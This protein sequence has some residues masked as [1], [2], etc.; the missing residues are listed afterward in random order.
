LKKLL[1]SLLPD[2]A[3]G[4]NALIYSLGTYS[5]KIIS[6]LVFPII[7]VE[8][9]LSDT[10]KY[11]LVL[12]TVTILVP[13]FS[14]QLGDAAY[15]WLSDP[16]EKQKTIGVTISA[17]LTMVMIV[18]VSVATL[19]LYFLSPHPLLWIGSLILISQILLGTMMQIVRGNG[20]IK[21]YT[22]VTILRSVI[23]S[24]ST[25]WAVFYTESKLQNVLFSFA[26]ANGVVLIL[27]IWK[28]FRKSQFAM[29]A[30]SRDHFK[31]ILN[32]VYPL[33]F[34]ALGWMMLINI[35]KYIIT[36][37]L[38]Y[39]MNGVFAIAEK[40]ATAIYFLG[41]FYFFSAQDH[42]LSMID[43]KNNAQSFRALLI[44][45]G[46][47]TSLGIILF[48]MASFVLMPILFPDLSQSIQYMPWL[49]V[50]NFLIIL[51][52][53]LGIPYTYEKKSKALATTTIIGILTVIAL[54][55]I[56]IKPLGLLGVC[57]AI[58]FGAMLIL[59]L[60]IRHVRSF[61]TQQSPL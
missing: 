59:M 23:F 45:V 41:I 5:S 7:A 38:G 27:C 61:F 52:I 35:N 3:I 19:L 47:F 34:N 49:A 24:A 10:G 36:A 39:E 33:I 57:I 51:S 6:M 14:L 48:V 2:K 30:L 58:C 40:F 55:F 20:H 46:S 16:D 37:E 17:L 21:L 9:G 50:A 11:D 1:S 22:N 60:R 43:L 15:R 18:F 28:G 44:K 42:F 26:M 25:L 53:Y 54:S 29:S 12:S 13:V 56:L 8:L 31:T 32:Y 4:R